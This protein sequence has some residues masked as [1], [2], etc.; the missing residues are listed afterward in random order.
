MAA[1]P[2]VRFITTAQGM[3][4]TNSANVSSTA[5]IGGTHAEVQATLR[6]K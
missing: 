5:I 6:S 2:V 3:A 1:Q 4:A